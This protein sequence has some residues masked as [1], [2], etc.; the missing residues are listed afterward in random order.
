M[1]F[2]EHFD[3][4]VVGAGHAGCEVE[5]LSGREPTGGPNPACFWRDGVGSG[6]PLAKSGA[7]RGTRPS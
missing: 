5:P 2:D 7:K 1:V 3:V 4:V 6:S